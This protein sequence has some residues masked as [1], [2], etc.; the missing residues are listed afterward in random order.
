MS[1]AAAPPPPDIDRT[2]PADGDVVVVRAS[3]A[4]DG[5]PVPTARARWTV[6]EWGTFRLLGDAHV[7]LPLERAQADAR[8]LAAARRR[9]AW[10]STGPRLLRLRR[11]PLVSPR[12]GGMY[13]L[14][15]D[16]TDVVDTRG[17]T[18]WQSHF[19]LTQAQALEVLAEHGFPGDLGASLLARARD[20]AALSS[21]E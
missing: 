2:E 7:D 18:Q 21:T 14:T 9:H 10:D 6:I 19:H 20:G 4:P 1:D 16:I 17:V 15:T 13:W 11:V 8:L 12:P 5:Q 3:L